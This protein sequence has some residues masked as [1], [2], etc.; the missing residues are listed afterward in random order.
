VNN[1]SSTTGI[2]AATRIIAGPTLGG[3]T[4]PD[5]QASAPPCQ[6]PTLTVVVWTSSLDHEP[7][8]SGEDLRG[9]LSGLL[10]QGQRSPFCFLFTLARTDFPANVNGMPFRARYA[11]VSVFVCP[12][13]GKSRPGP[14]H[15][16]HPV[17]DSMQGNPLG[18][19]VDRYRSGQSGAPSGKNGC[20]GSEPSEVA[21]RPIMAPCDAWRG[22]MAFQEVRGPIEPPAR[23]IPVVD[24][25]LVWTLSRD[26]RPRSLPTALPRSR[27]RSLSASESPGEGVWSREH[28]DRLTT[29]GGSVDRHLSVFLPYDRPPHHEDQL[30]RAA[31]IVM[32]AIPLARDALLA[33]LGPFSSARLPEPELDMQARDVLHVPMLSESEGLSLH[34]LI[35]V[36]VSPDEGL[37]LSEAEIEERTREQR[38]DGVLRFGDELVV[39]IES[40]VRGEAPSDQA[41]LLRLRGVEI[42]Q[43]KVTAL[44]WHQLLED[45]WALLERGLLAPAERVM[46]EDLIAFTEEHFAHLLPFTT[47]GRAG[48]NDLRRQ[49]RLAAVLR[50][51][52]CAEGVET[53]RRPEVGAVAMLDAAIGTKTT[54]RIALQQDGDDLALCTWLAELKPQAKALYQTTRA[55]K[56]VDFLDE[57]SGTW[58]ARP[59]VHLAFWR[60]P[61][62][63]RLYLN[64]QLEI[65]EYIHAWSQSDFGEVG[66]HHYDEIRDTLW[67][68]LQEHHYARPEDDPKL[69]P[70]LTLL[71]DRDAHLRPSIKLCR[72]WPWA[73]A[74]DLDDR[75]AL[76]TEVRTSVSELL[77]ALDEPLPA[78]WADATTVTTRGLPT[79]HA[80]RPW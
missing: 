32:R 24:G 41:K 8:L 56:L 69:N 53:M 44:G 17:R 79:V 58:R 68:W 67:P 26:R 12:A 61:V 78:A 37:D 47:L 36:F 29:T 6:T 21:S 57:H 1:T 59:N 46:M 60:A 16:R 42:R 76:V 7:F 77:T 62:S 38:L 43:S 22:W 51:V 34:Q 20:S 52:M 30:T 64:C 15:F 9:S 55:Q 10:D 65:S 80:T 2:T 70:F 35:S 50:E 13:C 31:M 5:N 73:H 4:G 54:Q 71:G 33:R 66:A 18:G 27:L 40:K 28:R 48:E 25:I 3:I 23:L 72:A 14:A 49:R 39:V 11:P 19:R 45:W 63:Q 75:G 74:V